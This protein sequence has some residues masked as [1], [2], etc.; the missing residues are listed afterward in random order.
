[1]HKP[2]TQARQQ[3]RET[4]RVRTRVRSAKQREAASRIRSAGGRLPRQVTAA[5]RAQARS[6]RVQTVPS[7]VAALPLKVATVSSAA[8]S[9]T[10]RPCRE[11][12]EKT[13]QEPQPTA[14]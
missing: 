11:A 6:R 13:F 5:R 14:P 1:M 8:R 3:L 10:G 4:I 12:S 9:N 2:Y 7:A